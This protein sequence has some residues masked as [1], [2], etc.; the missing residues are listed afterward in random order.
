VTLGGQAIR[1]SWDEILLQMKAADR[2]WAHGSLTDFMASLARRG[3]TETGVVIPTPTRR[4]SFV[5]A[6]KPAC[7]ES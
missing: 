5:V 7:C 1:G 4:P 6:P 3:Q 2:E